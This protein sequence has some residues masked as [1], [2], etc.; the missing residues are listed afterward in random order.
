MAVFHKASRPAETG[1]DQETEEGLDNVGN[2]D[3]TEKNNN[4]KKKKKNVET[5]ETPDQ[6]LTATRQVQVLC[7]L[8][9]LW[10][11]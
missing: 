6:R 9:F 7:L 4:A 11:K 5:V 2:D 8:L 10:N 3:S 1:E